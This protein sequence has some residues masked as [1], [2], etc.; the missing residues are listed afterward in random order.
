MRAAAALLLL[1]VR[2]GTAGYEVVWGSWYPTQ[3][4]QHG[5]TTTAADFAHF[6]ISYNEALSPGIPSLPPQPGSSNTGHANDSIV[7]FYENFGLY[8]AIGPHA[9]NFSGTSLYMCDPQQIVPGQPHWCN[10]GL[11]QRTNLTAHAIKIRSDIEIAIP[12]A[13]WSGLAF[14]D[15]ESWQPVW[16]WNANCCPEYQQASIAL[17]RAANPTWSAAKIEAQAQAELEAG[18]LAFLKHTIVVAQAARPK[19]KW[20]IDGYPGCGDSMD[21][22]SGVVQGRCP[23]TAMNGNDKLQSLLQMQDIV[24]PMTYLLSENASFN[25]GYLRVVFAEAARVAPAKPIY[26]HAWYEYLLQGAP[27]V[28]QKPGIQICITNDE[29]CITNDEFA[30]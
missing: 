11:P 28:P 9:G 3:C 15:Y 27:T 10:G 22:Y 24:V 30:L 13:S 14:I 16:D 21:D 26:Y 17:V 1:V 19:V 12:D 4:W 29:L 18:A 7:L 25:E 20:A 23:A 6:D 5:D 2:P 8:P